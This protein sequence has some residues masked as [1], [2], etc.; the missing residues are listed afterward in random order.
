MTLEASDK[1]RRDVLHVG[2]DAMRDAYGNR[3]LLDFTDED[4]LWIYNCVLSL[5]GVNLQPLTKARMLIAEACD[6]RGLTIRDD[7][8]KA[9]VLSK[10]WHNV[11]CAHMKV[12][13]TG[14]QNG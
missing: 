12:D 10:R 7:Q 3:W 14:R 5:H 6:A 8:A 11:V 1:R 4:L 13:K 2:E 9:F